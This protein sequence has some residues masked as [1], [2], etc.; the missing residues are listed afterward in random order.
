MPLRKHI[1]RLE[2]IYERY[3]RREMAGHDPIAFLYEY[4]DPADRE[5]AAVVASCLAY[6]RVAQILAS[7]RR[8]LDR[9]GAAPARF[10]HDSSGS[11][12]AAEMRGLRHRFTSGEDLARLLAGA[13]KIRRQQGSLRDCFAAGI[14]GGEESYI[15][16]ITR[17]AETLRAACPGPPMKFLL[18]SPRDGSACKRL[19]LM[20]RWL[21]RRDAVD[22]GGWDGISPAGLLIPLD[23]HMHRMCKMLGATRRA[24]A[25]LKAVIEAS[26]A[27]RLVRPDDP[28]RYD[29]ALTRPG[30]MALEK[31]SFKR[32]FSHE[33]AH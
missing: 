12:L 18:P 11:R 29:F 23:V 28:A 17:L 7:A 3:N 21:I 1:G 5:V 22:P 16:A 26:A 2:A 33:P 8:V 9:L 15:G 30:I 4:D 24:G 19:N 27:F 10:L 31:P 32:S 14:K 13:R 20:L 6:G 25:D